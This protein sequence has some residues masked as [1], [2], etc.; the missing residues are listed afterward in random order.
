MKPSFRPV[1]VVVS[2][3][4]RTARKTRFSYFRLLIIALP[5]Q[6]TT[7]Q[8][9]AH[10]I[11]V[12][13]FFQVLACLL[14]LG[15]QSVK[16]TF[17]NVTAKVESVFCFF[18]TSLFASDAVSLPES[19]EEVPLL[20]MNYKISMKTEN[21]DGARAIMRDLIQIVEDRIDVAP[22]EV[23][24][25]GIELQRKKLFLEAIAV[26]EVAMAMFEKH[27][28][29]ETKIN[30]VRWCLRCLSDTNI[31]MIRGV[32]S[33]KEVMKH[34]T[35]PLMREMCSHM[36]DTASLSELYKCL[37]V[38]WALYYIQYNQGLVDD[39]RHQEQALRK[40]IAD[41]GNVFGNFVGRNRV[42]GALLY[43]LGSV[44]VRN[45]RFEEAAALFKQALDAH[46]TAT[47]WENEE[48]KK[49]NIKRA[50]ISLEWAQKSVQN[51]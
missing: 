12:C 4:I 11:G 51:I 45:S 34:Y 9:L 7:L 26:L 14:C 38:S 50:E 13:K 42:Y 48:E 23:Q 33:M 15:L 16:K 6:K 32:S 27:P 24:F 18:E 43:D 40:A 8:Y 46:N 39:E 36:E 28:L 2:H 30:S 47:D 22:N 20:L 35:I 44:S 29:P 1:I 37:E 3:L 19:V 31:E 41:M 25:F 5:L 21:Y 49:T 10:E 17:S